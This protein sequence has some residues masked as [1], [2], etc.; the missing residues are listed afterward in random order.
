M[1]NRMIKESIHESEKLN[2]LSDFNFRLW[3]YL[4]TFV[5]DYGRGDARPKIIKGNCFPL[6]DRVT[7][8]DIDAGLHALA[9]TGCISLYEVGGKPYLYFPSWGEHQRIQT[10]RSR[11]PEPPGY[12]TA[13]GDLPCVTVDHG[14]S[15]PEVEGEAEAEQEPERETVAP[16][17]ARARA[18]ES[19][20]ITLTAEDVEAAR[21]LDDTIRSAAQNAGLTVTPDGLEYGRRLAVTYGLD[22]LLDAIHKAVDNPRWRYVEG[23]L[24]TP[25][26]PRQAFTGRQPRRNT[27]Q[28]KLA[29][30]QAD[31]E[32]G[33]YSDAS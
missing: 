25:D 3:V 6:R 12:S 29:Q 26:T 1:P 21:H 2:S 18:R 9:D 20:E 13:N 32:R 7:V 19:A 31:I 30:L 14:E 33:K 11:Y 5:D 15:L 16:P 23:I 10:K 4:L 8:N 22:A 28:D 27:V 17:P 24:S